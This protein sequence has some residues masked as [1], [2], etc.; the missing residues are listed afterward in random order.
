V[1]HLSSL[2]WWLGATAAA[3]VIAIG[4]VA[5]HAWWGVVAF[6]VVFA[7]AAWVCAGLI[8]LTQSGVADRFDAR[9]WRRRS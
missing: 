3:A 1:V 8:R 9:I 6:V 4:M 2:G 7:Y 5:A